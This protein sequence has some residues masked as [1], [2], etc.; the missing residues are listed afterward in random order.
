MSEYTSTSKLVISNGWICEVAEGCTCYGGGPYGHEPGCGL[1]A[2]MDI[3]EALAEYDREKD[4]E[5]ARLEK[6]LDAAIKVLNV[7][8][9]VV[10]EGAIPQP[11]SLTKAIGL[12]LG[13]EDE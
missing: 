4:A 6:K 5:I 9:N 2:I 7:V 8:E 11:G 13:D 3:S 12:I 1:D 10:T